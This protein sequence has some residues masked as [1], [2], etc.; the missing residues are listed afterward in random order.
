MYINHKKTIK[1]ISIII[2]I[3]LLIVLMSPIMYNI[4]CKQIGLNGAISIM[5]NDTIKFA[6]ESNLINKGS[7]NNLSIKEAGTQLTNNTNLNLITTP[8]PH[9]DALAS[10]PNA[11]KIEFDCNM[12]T[13]LGWEFKPLVS[14]IYTLPGNAFLV[15]FYAKNITNKDAIGTAIYNVTPVQAGQYFVK[16]QCFCFENIF[17]KAGQEIKMPVLFMIEPFISNNLETKTIKLIT[18]SYSFF[19]SE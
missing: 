12:S 6:L 5:K 7:L 13:K 8:G 10:N 16:I 19:L 4:I 9:N 2:C 3:M 15:Y 17:L 18:L 14:Y 1:L 11:I